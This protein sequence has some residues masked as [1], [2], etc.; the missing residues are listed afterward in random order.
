M[1]SSY[2]SVTVQFIEVICVGSC[3]L[4]LYKIPSSP[5][6]RPPPISIQLLHVFLRVLVQGCRFP[7][8]TNVAAAH[9]STKRTL[10]SRHQLGQLLLL[11]FRWPSTIA[12]SL[13]SRSYA[14]T[15]SPP[16]H[17]RYP[18]P[19]FLPGAGVV[20]VGS[21]S[22]SSSLRLFPRR[23][24]FSPSSSPPQ[25][26]KL[27]CISSNS[28]IVELLSMVVRVLSWPYSTA[29]VEFSGQERQTSAQRP[30]PH[31]PRDERG[32]CSSSLARLN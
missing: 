8:T 29:G 6:S 7:R 31:S 26:F 25:L 15:L 24:F 2:S 32:E 22:P 20:E 30:I 11:V 18:P 23:F 9:H 14:T 12:S 16:R 3:S 1:G 4:Y 21:I 27:F 19:L 10:R 28:A 5:S 13:V 17:P